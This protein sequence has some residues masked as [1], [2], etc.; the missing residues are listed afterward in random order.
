MQIE[1]RENVEIVSSHLLQVHHSITIPV[2]ELAE[3]LSLRAD[4]F[5]FCEIKL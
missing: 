4:P 1:M 2:S 3:L 5:R